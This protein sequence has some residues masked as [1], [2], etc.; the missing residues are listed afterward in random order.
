MKDSRSSPLT[1]QPTRSSAYGWRWYHSPVRPNVE[2]RVDARYFRALVDENAPDG[3]YFE[4]YGFLR[5]SAG[6]SVGF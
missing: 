1:V 5:L 3:G 4:D 2:V 6:V